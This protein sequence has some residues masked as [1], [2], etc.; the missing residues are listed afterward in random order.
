MM[1][2]SIPSLLTIAICIEQELEHRIDQGALTL[3]F[4]LPVVWHRATI[5]A[6]LGP[7]HFAERIVVKISS[8]PMCQLGS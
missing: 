7:V 6:S 3:V 1:S 8:P 4:A 5:E 2:L